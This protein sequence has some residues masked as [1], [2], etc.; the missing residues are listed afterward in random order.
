MY[1][2]IAGSAYA[3]SKVVLTPAAGPAGSL[4]RLHGSGFGRD[5]PVSIQ[6]GREPAMEIETS[7]RGRFRRRV[8]VPDSTTRTVRLT[9]RAGRSEMVNRFRVGVPRAVPGEVAST[10]GLSLRWSPVAVPAGAVMEL[11]GR[12]WP[13]GSRARVRAGSSQ[14]STN[15]TRDRALAVRLRLAGPAGR[16]RRVVVSAGRRSLAFPV[17]VLRRSAGYQPGFPIRAAFYYPWFP[18]AWRQR[19]IEPFT[20]YDPSAGFYSSDEPEVL[21]GHVRAMRHARLDA[22][23]VSW[24]GPGTKSDSRIPA[25]LEAGR[26]SRFRWA[27]YYE[28][29]GR[30]DPSPDEIRAD[31][32]YIR[33]Q[34]ASDPGY[35]R[36]NGRFVVFVWTEAEDREEMAGRWVAAR[37]AG[38]YVSLKVFSGYRTSPAQPDSWHQYAPA[39]PDMRVPDFSYAVSPGFWHAAESEPRLERS[40]A[41]FENSAQAMVRAGDPWQLVTT[42]NEWGEG[43]SIESASEWAS[44]S[45][46]GSFVDSLHRLLD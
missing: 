32:A 10:A 36:V 29:E 38:A 31:L 23:I 44:A 2:G 8:R 20:H 21:K 28:H 46:Y 18:E 39:E 43:T 25:L 24:W 26:D 45:G 41:R 14:W 12:G 42:F 37:D 4:V 30:G 5:Q 13:R 15:V 34:Y 3:A 16:T 27:L 17:E 6:I 1:S 19:G 9:T 40:G 35:L 22:A 33:E 11:T 7:A